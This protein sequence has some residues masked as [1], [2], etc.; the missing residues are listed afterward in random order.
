MGLNKIY[1]LTA[2]WPGTKGF[3]RIK[4]ERREERSKEDTL[5]KR[6]LHGL[7]TPQSSVWGGGG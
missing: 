6:N 4:P 5:N 1:I 7:K 2:D 3:V